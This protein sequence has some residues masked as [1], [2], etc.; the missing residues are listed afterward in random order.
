MGGCYIKKGDKEV[1]EPISDWG[2]VPGGRVSKERVEKLITFDFKDLNDLSIDDIFAGHTRMFKAIFYAFCTAAEQLWGEDKAMELV[3][4]M[5]Y[6]MGYKGWKAIMKRFNTDEV[7]PEQ[8]A[9]YQDMAHLFYGP[10]T[11]AYCEYD[12]EKIICTRERCLF[13][14]PEGMEHLGKYC[15][16]FDDSYIEAYMEAQPSLEATRE[17]FKKPDELK[18]KVDVSKYPSYTG[19]TVCQHVWI[20]KKK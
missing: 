6:N 5:G 11:H 8:C 17:T 19:G 15:S 4:R 9:W 12:E 20:N 13:K 14:P 3:K 18:Y 10:D 16:A 2:M 1:Y 7:S